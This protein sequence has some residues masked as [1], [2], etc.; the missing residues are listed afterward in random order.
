[1]FPPGRVE[2]LQRGFQN[3]EPPD[4]AGNRTPEA[5]FAQRIVRF[6]HAGDLGHDGLS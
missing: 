5:G 2:T 4:P 3:I 1:M 6:D